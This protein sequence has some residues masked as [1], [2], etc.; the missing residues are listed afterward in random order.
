MTT[1]TTKINAVLAGGGGA[2]G[3]ERTRPPKG[4]VYYTTARTRTPPTKP[5]QVPSGMTNK[6]FPFFQS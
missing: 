6:I 5:R 1:R 3:R 2:G 4:P